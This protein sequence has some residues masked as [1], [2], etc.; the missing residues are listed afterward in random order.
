MHGQAL[1][2]G[3]SRTPVCTD[4]HGIHNILKPF[5]GTKD[6][7]SPSVGTDSCAKCHEG[8][9]LTQE[10]SV[11]SGRVSSYRDSY[12]GLASQLGSKVVANC[13]SCNGVHNILPSSDSRSLISSAHLLQT[14]GQCHVVAREHFIIVKI[15]LTSALFS[16]LRTH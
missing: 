5:E 1:A 15:H 9:T 14:W 4:C 10:F 3:V 11:A 6:T 2:R 12:H 7:I 16:H 13:A 8:V